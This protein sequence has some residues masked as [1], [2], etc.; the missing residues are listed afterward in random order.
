MKRLLSFLLFA[1]A[2]FAAAAQSNKGVKIYGYLQPVVKGAPPKKVVT[3]N[4]QEIYFE[5]KPSG[6]IIIYLTYPTSTALQPDALYI[7]GK[8]YKVKVE[9]IEQT[10]VRIT[11]HNLP[12]QPKTTELVPK[13]GNKV[14]L[15][16]PVE[17]VTFKPGSCLKRKMKA[18][19]VV[20]GYT[21]K[22]KRKYATA[23]KLTRL[24]PAVLQ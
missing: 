19:E 5:Q 18:N 17:P 20:I 4:N 1:F 22:G 12:L 24:E 15:I 16:T 14:V 8:K 7:G 3:E 9:N 21:V 6:N 11:D 23:E 13:T 2:A 10:P